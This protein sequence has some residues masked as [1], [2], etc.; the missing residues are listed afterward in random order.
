MLNKKDWKRAGTYHYTMEG[1]TI[2]Y[3]KY[4]N[5][6]SAWPPKKNGEAHTAIGYYDC[7]DKAREE[8]DKHK[9]ESINSLQ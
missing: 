2:C 7:P 9:S 8:C 3:H 6:W 1:Y 4:E 5:K